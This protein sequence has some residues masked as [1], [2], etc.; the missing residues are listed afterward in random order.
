M[1]IKLLTIAVLALLLCA[2]VPMAAMAA[3]QKLNEKV[4]LYTSG[5]LSKGSVATF[6]LNTQTGAWTLA[7]VNVPA[8]EYRLG[9]FSATAGVYGLT[10]A[11][12]VN[13]DGTFTPSSGPNPAGA[14]LSTWVSNL[15]AGDKVVLLPGGD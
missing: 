7:R 13:A 6:T 2:T 8:G 15:R 1:K 12:T 5:T 10:A 9:L 4:Y 3:P 11:V 14:E